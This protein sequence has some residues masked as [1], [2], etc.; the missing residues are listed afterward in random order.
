MLLGT[1]VPHPPGPELGQ[2]MILAGAETVGLD[3]HP[4][5]NAAP[6]MNV[7]NDASAFHRCFTVSVLL[8]NGHRQRC[9]VGGR[10]TTRLPGRV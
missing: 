9:Q 5:S 4:A 8:P 3:E 1:V 2:E 7:I 6:A 10:Y